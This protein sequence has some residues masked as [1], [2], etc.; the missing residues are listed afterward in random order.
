M[1]RFEVVERRVGDT[2]LTVGVP[3]AGSR[4]G[5]DAWADAI[6]DVTGRLEE[7]LGPYPYP[8]LWTSV[9]PSQSSGVEFPTAPQFGDVHRETVRELAAHEVAHM[10]FYALVGNNQARHP[11]IDESFATYAQARAVGRLDG[12]ALSDIPPGLR[13]ELGRPMQWW[14]E[15]GSFDR[16]VRGVYDQGAALLIEGRRRAGEDAFDEALRA[17]LATHAHQVVEP[18]DVEAAFGDLPE[19]VDLLRDGGAIP[20]RT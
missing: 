12:Y 15:R 1:G 16:Y 10:W 6:S 4:V 18:A 2:R 20:G 7:F 17:Y 13:G 14:A 5:A 19:V 3:E 9:V 11:W 8:D